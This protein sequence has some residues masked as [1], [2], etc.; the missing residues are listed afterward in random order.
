MTTSTIVWIVVAVAVALLLIAAVVIVAG[1][2]R[3]RRR[4]LQAESIR[5]RAGE[6]TAKVE[7]REAL[8]NET[9]ARARAAQAEAEAKAAEAARLHESA[10]AHHGA[11]AE[12][13]EQL[14]EQFAHADRIDP[15]VRAAQNRSGD[16]RAAEEASR[17]T[18]GSPTD[19]RGQPGI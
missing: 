4:R 6:E 15:A 11:V 12:S 5:Q 2:A 9:A 19:T 13:R 1:R 7:R 3:T 14:N 10:A 18:D 17:Q 8:A 16:D